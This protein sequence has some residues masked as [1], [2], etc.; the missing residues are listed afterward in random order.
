MLLTLETKLRNESDE[1]LLDI[2]NELSSHVVPA[3]GYAHRYCKN[4]NRLIDKG[5]MCINPT[6]F[7]KVYLPTLVK[8]VNHELALRYA[9]QVLVGKLEI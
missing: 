7:R 2:F 1:V 3:T 5:E 6:T 8:A 4:I 9:E